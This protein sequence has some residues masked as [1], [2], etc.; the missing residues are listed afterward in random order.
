MAKSI[1]KRL[2]HR[3]ITV[4]KQIISDRAGK[5][6]YTESIK[7]NKRNVRQGKVMKKRICISIAGILVLSLLTGCSAAGQVMKL[8]EQTAWEEQHRTEQ[9]EEKEEETLWKEEK[10]RYRRRTKS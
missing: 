6:C 4:E 3:K 10:R 2:V 8:W 1:E 9:E 7:W 5:Y